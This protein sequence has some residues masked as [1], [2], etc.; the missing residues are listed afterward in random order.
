[1]RRFQKEDTQGEG[2]LTSP[3]KKA[4]DAMKIHTALGNKHMVLRQGQ[5]PGRGHGM[6]DFRKEPH[7]E[8]WTFF[9][10]VVGNITF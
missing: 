6:K 7:S 3:E 5:D 2:I 4:T 1:M 8:I 10:W 9:Q